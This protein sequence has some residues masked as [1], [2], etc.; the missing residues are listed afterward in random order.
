MSTDISFSK[1]NSQPFSGNDTS[2]GNREILR[3]Y[4]VIPPKFHLVPP[5][6]LFFPRWI[7]WICLGAIEEISREEFNSSGGLCNQR[8]SV[9]ILELRILNDTPAQLPSGWL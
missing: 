5:K 4:D 7:F 2:E 6:N 1:K 3:T 9:A 8:Y